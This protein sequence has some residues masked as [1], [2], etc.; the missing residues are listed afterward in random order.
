MDSRSRRQRLHELLGD[1]QTG[2]S[3]IDLATQLGVTE[4]TVYRD[5][6]ALREQGVPVVAERGRNGGIRLASQPGARV[7]QSAESPQIQSILSHG[8][9]YVGR[10]TELDRVSDLLESAMG[11]GGGVAMLT[12]EPGIGKTRTAQEV[13]ERAR[14]LGFRAVWG[15]CLESEGV[16]AFWPWSQVIR[17]LTDDLGRERALEYMGD[18][19]A[20]IATFS[21]EIREALP[22]FTPRAP[23]EYP[24]PARFRIYESINRF[25]RTTAQEAPL[26]IV[27][28][29][30]QW[31]DGPS[32]AVL[33]FMAS[34]L[35]DSQILVIG[36]YRDD[37]VTRRHPLSST[38]GE[39]TRLV[40]PT[41]LHLKG[42]TR[43]EVSRYLEGTSSFVPRRNLASTLHEQTNGN[44]LFLGEIIRLLDDS[45]EVDQATTGVEHL[46]AR[47]PEGVRDVI[48]RRLDRLSETCNDV[49]ALAAVISRQFQVSVLTRASLVPERELY[50][51][52]GEAEAAR[53]IEPVSGRVD[54][55]QFTHPLMR[56]TLYDEISTLSRS[57]MHRD[58]AEA[59]E[60]IEAT[61]IELYMPQLAHH[62]FEAS[63][64]GRASK[65]VEYCRRAARQAMQQL[66]PDESA[67]FCGMALQTLHMIDDRDEVTECEL[68]LEL[69]DAERDSGELLAATATFRRASELAIKLGSP[70][71]Q[72]RAA[73]GF[74]ETGWRPG[75]PGDDSVE[76]LDHAL[77]VLPKEDSELRSKCLASRYRALVFS[78]RRNEAIS[79]W[80]E[81]VAIARRLED[82]QT[83]TFALHSLL[84]DRWWTDVERRIAVANE[85]IE[86]AV[87]VG[88]WDRAVQA[89]SYRLGY[90]VDIGD[91][92][93]FNRTLQTQYQEHTRLARHPFNEYVLAGWQAV[94]ALA[95][96]RL[97]DAEALCRSAL[98]MGRRLKGH[99][100]IGVFGVQMFNI[101]RTQGRL[102]EL[103]PIVQQFVEQSN[104]GAWR[105]GLALMYTELGLRDE[106]REQFE[107]LAKD[108][109]AGVPADVL[110]LGTMSYLAEICSF[111]GDTDRARILYDLLLPFGELN[112]TIGM[113]PMPLGSVQMYLGLL[114]YTFGELDLAL[115][116]HNAAVLKSRDMGSPP[117]VARAELEHGI[118]LLLSSDSGD[119]ERGRLLL[120][121]ARGIAEQIGMA[122]LLARI[123][124]IAELA[125]SK[126]Q[127]YP[128]GLTQREVEVLR[129]I[130]D[131][132]SNRLISEQL[133]IT[134]NT[135]ANH[136]KSILDKTESVNRTEAAAFAIRTGLLTDTYPI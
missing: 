2:I 110:W 107:L 104:S 62:Y 15:R 21:N 55:Y 127:P 14:Q 89:G 33:E 54:E 132:V 59:I 130:A 74:E 18:G 115:D 3:A 25:L 118:L 6:D 68:L 10:E 12:G 38:L 119:R 99:D 92:R 91:Y 72:A 16:P 23:L 13:S 96:G 136:V 8:P 4:R 52:L 88:D 35:A 34:E 123:T 121:S 19:A 80:E 101:R 94:S 42:F 29:D 83:L 125:V 90:Y 17:D 9:E 45:R 56:E 51:A 71:L 32:L 105:P 53:L 114:A 113:P 111:L 49:L 120:E 93:T 7:E 67:S 109:F 73:L 48:G 11:A 129:L 31:A 41:R 95:E 135:V 106:A 39:L 77:A 100:S 131:G 81:S 44:P 1:T 43:A 133:F 85:V 26:L 116:H 24:A 64:S 28:D 108:D 30:L 37:E 82:P 22:Q 47:V 76:L 134:Q 63:R 84:Y 57:N 126:P 103:A 124:S 60:E 78:G 50:D 98:P 20:D 36:T 122:G 97:S 61:R 128:A 117:L 69:G 66:A 5:V 40:Q 75:W 102:G 65:A 87:G 58:I 27:L 70:F 46:L 112:S 79:S 86:I